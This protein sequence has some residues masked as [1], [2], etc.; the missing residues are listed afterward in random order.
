[1]GFVG[2]VE[3]PCLAFD[4]DTLKSLDALV[5]KCRLAL[6]QIRE[7][8]D[9]L[10]EFLDRFLSVLLMLFQECYEPGREG[11]SGRG[12]QQMGEASHN[13]S[14]CRSCTS[15][16]A[17]DLPLYRGCRKSLA[18]GALSSPSELVGAQPSC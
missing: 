1:M 9:I 18:Q 3:S 10:L 17:P 7:N 12:G 8:R 6:A 14:R 15:D 13:K 4:V 5:N 2:E 11:A 16:A